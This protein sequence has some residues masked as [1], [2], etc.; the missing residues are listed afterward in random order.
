MLVHAGKLAKILGFSTNLPSCAVWAPGLPG[1]SNWWDVWD[2][3][4]RQLTFRTEMEV[5]EFLHGIKAKAEQAGVS[6][7]V[8]LVSDTMLRCA[9]AHSAEPAWY[10]IE[11]DGER[12]H[13]A[14]V[15]PNRWL[16]ESSEA[17]LL[18]TG[19]P[20]EE[21]IEEEMAELRLSN[22]PL[23]VQHYRSDDTLYTFRS[24]PPISPGNGTDLNTAVDIAAR[25]L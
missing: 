25:W 19:D 5:N 17:D 10:R 23:R 9:A 12:W 24:P 18:Q 13:V 1:F 8:E 4:K 14:L 3:P 16:S 7:N 15:T 2:W 20:L 11:R 22:G 21:L 6:G